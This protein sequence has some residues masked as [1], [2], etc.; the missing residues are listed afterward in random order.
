MRFDPKK[1]KLNQ[2]I[3]EE[4]EALLLDLIFLKK[5]LKVVKINLII[6]SFFPCFIKKLEN[7]KRGSSKLR[8]FSDELF[9]KH[10]GT[11]IILFIKNFI[12]DEFRMYK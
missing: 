8:V 7:F 2:E 9:L 6:F 11:S 3:K 1:Y 12:K 10:T 5:I 4:F